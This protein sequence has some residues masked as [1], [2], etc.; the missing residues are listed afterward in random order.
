[1]ANRDALILDDRYNGGGFI[2]DRMIALL[3]RPL[4]SYWVTRDSQP[5]P[6]PA[7]ANTGPKVALI[8]GQAGSGGDAFPFYFKKM[9]L[10]PVIGTRT[11]GG[12]IGLS[13]SPNLVDGGLLSVP[14]FRFLTTEG[15]WGVENEGVTPDIEVEDRPDALAK[16]QDPTLEKG[17]EVLMEA[18]KKNPPKKVTVPPIPTG[19][20]PR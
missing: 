14:T 3:S 13:G 5:A 2:P 12:L 10:G 1:M 15:Q 17:I 16:G 4:L 7:F 11:W 19:G 18:L 8:N 9:G 20:K 6:T